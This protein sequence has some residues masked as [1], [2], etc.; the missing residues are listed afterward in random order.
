MTAVAAGGANTLAVAEADPRR[1]EPDSKE[2]GEAT[3][4]ALMELLEGSKAL[5]AST[6]PAAMQARVVVFDLRLTCS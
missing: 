3:S 5:R 2:E 6:Q 4:A 1:F